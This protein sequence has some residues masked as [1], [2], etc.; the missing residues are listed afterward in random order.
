MA[1][2]KAYGIERF[3]RES[4]SYRAMCYTILH[5]Q[6]ALRSVYFNRPEW[7]DLQDMKE[8]EKNLWDLPWE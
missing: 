5:E 8:L 4:F 1:L 3:D 6:D 2:M 7:R